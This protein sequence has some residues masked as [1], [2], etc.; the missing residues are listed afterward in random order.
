M[1]KM[2]FTLQ[3]LLC[4]WR[5][6]TALISSIGAQTLPLAQSRSLQARREPDST[7][8]GHS[9]PSRSA[10]V[11]YAMPFHSALHC[12]VLYSALPYVMAEQ[13]TQC[14]M[15]VSMVRVVESVS[16]HS[17]PQLCTPCK[18][19]LS[20]SVSVSLSFRQS[21]LILSR[22]LPLSLSPPPLRSEERAVWS[23][24]LHEPTKIAS[25]LYFCKCHYLLWKTRW[26][27]N[28]SQVCTSAMQKI[29][30]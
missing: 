27:P 16:Q 20:V 29:S 11:C 17:R 8:H 24:T 22:S 18:V 2:R 25:M 7:L 14:F 10:C 13:W 30:T 1:E 12:A 21:L 19:S 26:R 23:L 3:S 9:L 6:T 15:A 4:L 5:V 28:D